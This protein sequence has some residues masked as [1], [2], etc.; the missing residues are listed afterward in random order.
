M[1]KTSKIIIILIVFSIVSTIVIPT[2]AV[3]SKNLGLNSNSIFNILAKLADSTV[4]NASGDYKYGGNLTVLSSQPGSIFSYEYNSEENMGFHLYTSGFCRIDDEENRF[5]VIPEYSVNG[6]EFVQ[7]I[8]QQ[9]SVSLNL[10]K[11]VNTLVVRLPESKDIIYKAMLVKYKD[12]FIV[13]QNSVCTRL[14]Y[15]TG[16]RIYYVNEDGVTE[17]RYNLEYSMDNGETFNKLKV[18]EMCYLVFPVEGGT[19]FDNKIIIREKDTQNIIYETPTLGDIEE[20]VIY[21]NGKTTVKFKNSGEDIENIKYSYEI[22]GQEFEGN[23]F[24]VEENTKVM[25]NAEANIEFSNKS[26]EKEI[27][28]KVIKVESPEIKIDEENNLELVAGG[29]KNDTLGKIY[30]KIDDGEYIEYTEKVKLNLEPGSHAIKAYQVSKDEN[31]KSDEVEKEITIEEKEEVVYKILEGDNQTYVIGT[32]EE[33]TIKASGNISEF[34]ELKVDGEKLDSANYQ[35]VSGSTVVTLKQAY[36]NTLQAGTHKLTFV[37]TDGEVSAEFVIAKTEVE[38]KE[39]ETV[40]IK[41]NKNNSSTPKTGDKIIIS[42]IVLLVVI[43]L[44]IVIRNK[45]NKQ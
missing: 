3:L 18:Q 43:I 22:D 41:N 44:N 35:V 39:S 5:A 37:Y 7:S 25:L 14:E 28:V 24:E 31:V 36:L 32:D 11:D 34:K 42:I 38:K 27:E 4:V 19:L 13:F 30:Y 1:K 8:T 20:D 15:S 9:G 16:D 23:E 2:L 26:A 21:E 6:A 12:S 10:D 29:V 17:D 45:K 40:K 33:L